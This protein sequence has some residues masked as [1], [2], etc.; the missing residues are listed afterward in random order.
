M[1]ISKRRGIKSSAQD[2]FL[3]PKPIVITS[4]TMTTGR[5]YGN[6][7]VDIVYYVPAD[8]PPATLIT[9]TSSPATTTQTTTNMTNYQFTGLSGGTT[10]TFT[11]VASNAA[12]NAAGTTTNAVS[13]ITVPQAPS[14]PTAT[15]QV[16]Q[17]SVSWSAPA[18]NGGSAITG[19]RLKSSDGPTY[20]YNA[21]ITSATISETGGTSQTYSVAALNAQGYSSYSSNSNQVTTQSPF[22]PFFPPFFPY[23]PPFFPFFPYFP[24]YFPYFPPFFPFFPYFPPFFPFFPYF[25]P[26]FPYFPYFPPFFPYFPYFPP[27]FPYFP[28]FPPFFPYFPFFPFFP[29]FG[30]KVP[31]YKC[32]SLDSEV[33]SDKGWIKVKDVKVGDTLITIHP[34]DFNYENP[35]ATITSEKVQL[36]ETKVSSIEYSE[37]M[38]Y[39]LNDSESRYSGQQPIFIK[40]GYLFV[41]T[42]VATAQEGSMMLKV[43][44]NGNVSEVELSSITEAGESTVA[45]IKTEEFGWLITKDNVLMF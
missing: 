18:N 24:P 27:F 20:D 3:E 11:G 1:A 15:A 44:E 39:K 29:G 43:D 16:N 6:G 38:T 31:A 30:G 45:D 13:I 14:A 10:Y 28:Y 12:G 19:Y 17:D 21:S 25:P 26:F 22:F 9:W 34:N 36:V 35:S 41:A 4:V 40:F 37:K 42:E 23:F 2:N 5:P 8:S 33:L 32:V 7:A